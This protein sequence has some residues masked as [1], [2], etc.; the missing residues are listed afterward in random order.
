MLWFGVSN[1]VTNSLLPAAQF[2]PVNMFTLVLTCRAV[3]L[4][5]WCGGQ[6]WVDGQVCVDEGGRGD[7]HHGGHPSNVVWREHGHCCG[8]CCLDP[9]SCFIHYL[10]ERDQS[11]VAW[12]PGYLKELIYPVHMQCNTRMQNMVW[13][14][15]IFC[16]L[17][18]LSSQLL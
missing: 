2:T 8:H 3:V 12:Q 11:H 7:G 9:L 15:L 14:K 16:G 17:F 13:H 5:R 6:V 10:R 1:T 18:S 4:Q